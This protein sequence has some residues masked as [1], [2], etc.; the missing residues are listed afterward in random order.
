MQS[1]Y[2]PSSKASWFTDILFLAITFTVLYFFWLGSYPLFTPDE[3]RY[4]EIAREMLAYG[5]FVTPKVNGVAFLD[6]P[7]LYYW[8]QAAALHLFG[9]HE[10]AARFFPALYGISGCLAVYLATRRLFNRIAG[11]L[12]AIILATT[13]LYFGGSHY[14]NMD[15]EV[16]VLVSSSL[17]A[18]IVAAD[19]R[20]GSR[21]F[22]F[23]LA[24]AL[25]ALAF[26][27]KGLLAIAFPIMIC[28]LWILILWRWNLL[29]KMRIGLGIVVFTAITLPWFYLVQQ[30]NPWFLHFFFVTQHITRFLSHADFNNKLPVWFYGPVV[31]AGFI[32]WTA[33]LLQAAKRA[34]RECMMARQRHST[35]LF[36][37]LWI[38]VVFIFFSIPKSKIV[39][40]ILPIFPPMAMLVGKYLSDA[41]DR[42]ISYPGIKA[43]VFWVIFINLLLAIVLLELPL[44]NWVDVAP[45][46]APYLFAIAAE[47]TIGAILLFLLRK[48]MS[49]LKIF[50]ICALTCAAMLLTVVMSASHTNLRSAKPL[51]TKLQPVLQPQ[52]IVVNYF[53]F[54]EDVPFYL[55][56]KIILVA[57]W[58]NPTVAKRDNWKRELSYAIPYQK[59]DDVLLTENAFWAMWN[60]YK[61][62]YVFVN[63]NYMSQ[64]QAQT[65]KSYFIGKNNDI[66]LLSNQPLPAA[67]QED[68]PA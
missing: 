53:K 21:S 58:D 5:N 65:D 8:L 45:G 62:V 41:W 60:D 46:I 31:L 3:G 24:Y 30:E 32:P 33:F 42:G 40:Y 36:L 25:A 43:G 61:R 19:S 66:Y 20:G 22:L 52:D 26:L 57:D 68:Q 11:L 17:L 51:I 15:L 37:L 18:F 16:A 59:T 14:A 48:N 1:N 35:E 54:Y 50:M 9:I 12:A 67:L 13:P 63:E 2:Y 28:G 10:W 64:F 56:R 23:V 49:T 4:T 38:A 47:L 6:K 27:T 44:H 39:T 7:I 29:L 55:Q 34:F